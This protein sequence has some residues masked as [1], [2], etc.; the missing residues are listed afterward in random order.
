M[1][2]LGHKKPWIYEPPELGKLG[3]RN[4]HKDSRDTTRSR[5]GNQ[6][7]YFLRATDLCEFPTFGSGLT[8]PRADAQGIGDTLPSSPCAEVQG[9]V[10]DA[11]ILF[12]N[13]EN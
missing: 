6:V 2:Y 1:R 3:Q 7:S 4:R 8:P 13:T 12:I 11:T 9:K 10:P 5:L